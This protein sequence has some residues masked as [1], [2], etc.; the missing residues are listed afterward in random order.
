MLTGLKSIQNQIKSID[1]L[2]RKFVCILHQQ[3]IQKLASNAKFLE[4]NIFCS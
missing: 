1:I 2:N 3:R 4:S